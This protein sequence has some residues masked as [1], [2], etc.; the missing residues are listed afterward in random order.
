MVLDTVIATGN[1]LSK[2]CDELWAMSGEKERCITVMS[3]YASPEGL[4]IVTNYPMVKGVY[5]GSVA[6]TVDKNGYLV[7]YTNGDIGDKLFG[8]RN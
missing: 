3:C 8:A 5:V 1:T 2:V 4:A 6:E 7:P